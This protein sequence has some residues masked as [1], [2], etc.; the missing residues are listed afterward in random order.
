MKAHPPRKLC[1][2]LPGPG[3]LSSSASLESWANRAVDAQGVPI[4]A[5]NPVA[6]IALTLLSFRRP[7]EG[8]CVA[9]AQL[10]APAARGDCY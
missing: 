9:P 6:E 1:S 5:A 7:E 2:Y 4:S 3:A 8:V 10:I